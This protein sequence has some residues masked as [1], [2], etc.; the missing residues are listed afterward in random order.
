MRVWSGPTQRVKR[1]PPGS[2]LA[3]WS[4][5]PPQSWRAGGPLWRNDPPRRG[6]LQMLTLGFRDCQSLLG[7]L[8]ETRLSTRPVHSQ[9]ASD[10]LFSFLIFS[11]N[12]QMR[13]TGHWRQACTRKIRGQHQQRERA[14][15]ETANSGSRETQGKQK[16]QEK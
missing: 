8:D 13:I 14:P 3:V 9:Q 2:H 15:G 4:W 10:G 6:A 5:S 12:S 1:R 7:C 11:V 16:P